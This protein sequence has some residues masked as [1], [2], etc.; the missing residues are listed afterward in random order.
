MVQSEIED[1]VNLFTMANI[2]EKR[3]RTLCV[4]NASAGSLDSASIT[5]EQ[6]KISAVINE[7]LC[8]RL[9]DPHR[10]ARDYHHFASK[11]HVELLCF[12]TIG[13]QAVSYNRDISAR[14]CAGGRRRLCGFPSSFVSAGGGVISRRAAASACLR[15]AL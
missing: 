10:G 2:A 15:A 5:G 1:A 12:P 7:E 6:H 13:S 11:F 3:Q 8:D 9:A 4:A 14:A